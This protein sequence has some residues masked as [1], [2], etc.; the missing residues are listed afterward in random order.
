[1]RLK[2]SNFELFSRQCTL[3]EPTDV[4][5]ELLAAGLEL[6]DRFDHPGPFRL[7]GLTAISLLEHDAS[8]QL[9]LL[10]REK[11]RTLETTLDEIAERF[12]AGALRRARDLSDATVID[13]GPNLDFLKPDP[14]D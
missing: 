3:A 14:I 8:T 13:G 5:S 4:A 12:G 11:D 9:S 7:V 2:T 6:L 1:M 10:E